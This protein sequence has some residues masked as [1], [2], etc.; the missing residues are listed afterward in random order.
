MMGYSLFILFALFLAGVVGFYFGWC[1]CWEDREN[2][3]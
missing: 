3:E 2:R 1:S